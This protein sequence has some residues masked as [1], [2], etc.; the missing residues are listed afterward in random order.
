[1]CRSRSTTKETSHHRPH[2][3]GISTIPATVVA[4]CPG[5]PCN[6][7]PSIWS[8]IASA[9]SRRVSSRVDPVDMHPTSLGNKPPSCGPRL[10]HNRLSHFFNPVCFNIEVGSQQANRRGRCPGVVSVPG[11]GP[12]NVL[13]IVPKNPIHHPSILLNALP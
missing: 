8:A 4:S 1:W 6:Q 12:I 3:A 11:V 10:E 7:S 9:I 5:S 2:A 13:I